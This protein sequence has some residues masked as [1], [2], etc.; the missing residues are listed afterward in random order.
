MIE[1]YRLTDRLDGKPCCKVRRRDAEAWVKQELAQWRKNGKAVQLT[2]TAAE[3]FDTRSSGITNLECE[4]NAGLAKDDRIAAARCKVKVWLSV[5]TSS[6][7]ETPTRAPLPTAG[8]G[9]R[10]SLKELDEAPVFQLYYP[11][12]TVR[13]RPRKDE[14][15]RDE[16][17]LGEHRVDLML[18]K[19]KERTLRLLDNEYVQEHYSNDEQES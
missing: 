12:A 2:E 8:G 5:G 4:A 19:N 14:L 10:I 15:W 6:G 9:R 11:A 17:E 16:I 7:C 3:R 18:R 13:R 1:A